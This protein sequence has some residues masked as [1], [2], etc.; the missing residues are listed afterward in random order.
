MSS[1]YGPALVLTA[2]TLTF[3]NEWLQTNNL[4]WR[5]PVATLLGAGVMAAIGAVST[6]AAN[7]LGVMVLIAAAS[8]EFNGKSAVQEISS[9]LP[10]QKG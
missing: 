1:N 3:G 2:G 8:T 9:S 6:G 5:V 4:N 7:S 10:K